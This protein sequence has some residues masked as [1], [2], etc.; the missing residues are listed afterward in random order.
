MAK[1]KY[2]SDAIGEDIIR[3][4]TQLICSEGHLKTLIEKK[5]AELENGII[6]NDNSEEVCKALD[7]IDNYR[8]EL[9][10]IAML[11][12][13]MMKKLY[14][15]FESENSD[16][17]Y[18]CQVKHLAN[19]AYCAFEAYQA[20]DNDADL[21]HMAIEINKQFIRALTHFLGIEITTCA[22]CFHDAMK[23]EM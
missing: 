11:R 21:Y 23:G 20:S 17:T 12:R 3:S 22:S 6:D 2:S 5:T 7:A 8:E 1:N 18:W 9:D 15:M 19:S 10:S 13:N 14:D 4:F 16:L